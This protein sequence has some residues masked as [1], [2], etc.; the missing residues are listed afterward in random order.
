MMPHFI[1]PHRIIFTV[2]KLVVCL[3]G[4]KVKECVLKCEGSIGGSY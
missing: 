3:M 4:R 1:T 2:K